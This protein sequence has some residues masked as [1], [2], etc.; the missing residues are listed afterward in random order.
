MAI[1]FQKELNEEQYEAVTYTEG[2]LLIIAG[3][4]TGKTRTMT[5]RAAYLIDNGVAPSEILMLTFTNKAANEMKA[6]VGEL[7][8]KDKAD[9][10]T[11]CTFHSF[12]TRILRKYGIQI[13]I[14][15]NFV[16][17]ASG[18]DADIIN[19]KK[20]EAPKH[21]YD[22]KGFPPS[23]KIVDIISKSVNKK[24]TIREI[25][26]NQYDKYIDF[27]DDITELKMLSDKYKWENSMLNY[28]DMLLQ[29]NHLLDSCPEVASQISDI[30][31][32][33]MVDEY[34]DTNSLQDYILYSLRKTNRNI[35]VVGDDMQSLYAFRGAEV[36]N[37][38]TFERRVQGTKVIKLVKNYRSCQE[39]LDLSNYAAKSATEGYPKNL[40]GLYKSGEK[41]E[42]CQ[43][44]SQADE[45]T[46][47]ID[48]VQ[49]LKKDGFKYEDI[50]ILARNS[51]ITAGLESKLNSEGIAYVKYGGTKFFDLDYVKTVLSYFRVLVRPEDEIAWFRILKV[52]SG[53]G[54]FYA[55][56]IAAKCKEFGVD[57]LLDIQYSKRKYSEGLKSL[58]NALLDFQDK[59]LKSMTMAIIE[60][61]TKTNLDRIAE[62][63]V[64]DESNRTSYA[65]E[66]NAHNVE[67]I[68]SLIPI[69]EHYDNITD[70]LDDL[71][72]DNTNLT[73]NNEEE[74]AVVVST[75]HSIKGLE[76]RAVIVM[77]CIDEIFPSVGIKYKGSREDNEELRC[78]YVAVTRAKEKL[79]L[80]QPLNA[81]S[82]GKSI[83]GKLSH[84]LNDGQQ[85]YD[86][87][88]CDSGDYARPGFSGKW[89]NSWY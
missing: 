72:L 42:V 77:D 10:I 33:I 61:Y 24:Q 53:I 39:I 84:Y 26:E 66:A 60:F 11:A 31:N 89:F 30:Y 4:G 36:D 83:K 64:R 12:C 62:M 49:K 51:I 32:Y 59:D 70:F 88:E 37:I 20:T 17:L 79:Y 3:A 80:I 75:I 78:F 85:Y 57:H 21:K 22:K 19:M 65:E 29:M 76:Y 69:V 43:V 54:D 47:I 44:Y 55:K 63:N 14:D 68:E 34:Q 48:I 86:F 67:L 87:I 71:V 16:I 35:A 2:P 18:D 6:R 58:Y 28:D 25:V 56:Q 9:G 1:D 74:G 50:C 38:L 15:H 73:Q 5:Y 81:M 13:G 8:G 52:H 46:K 45:G 7:L 41:P 82:Y 23:S 27:I 40:I